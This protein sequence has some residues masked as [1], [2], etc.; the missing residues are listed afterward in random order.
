MAWVIG[1]TALSLIFLLT[2]RRDPAETGMARLRRL[3]GDSGEYP[4]AARK[5]A[6]LRPGAVV[7]LPYMVLPGALRQRV[8][9]DLVGL[10]PLSAFTVERLAGIRVCASLGLP[11][12]L[13]L[14]M[15]FNTASLIMAMPVTA[16]GVML[17]RLLAGR[18]RTG[19]FESVR[20]CLP[21]MADMLYAFV[22][23]G[24]NLDQAFRG[25]AETTPEPLGSLLRQAVREVELGASR[26]EAFSRM[27]ARCPLPELSS[28]LRSLSEAERRGHALSATL[29]V[30]SR[31]IRLRRRDQLKVAVA[32]APLKMLAPLVFLILPASV[33]LTVGPTF[34]ATLKKVF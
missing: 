33:L 29:G 10:A 14:L 34:L 3:H 19:Y 12:A 16:F 5:R 1:A 11:I 32:K 22:L 25:A 24:K 13:V 8:A 18:S 26:E 30:F 23:G 15:K 4:P 7:E 6:A 27:L 28:L 9:S 2:G 17:P 21:H 31:E 20:Q